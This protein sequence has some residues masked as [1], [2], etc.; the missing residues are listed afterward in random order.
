ML[1]E[2]QVNEAAEVVYD[3]VDPSANLIFGAVIDESLTGQVSLV[4][5]NSK[6]IELFDNSC[7]EEMITV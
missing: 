5:W 3:L 7:F 2:L 4:G 1:F 6:R